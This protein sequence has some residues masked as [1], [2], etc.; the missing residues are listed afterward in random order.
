MGNVSRVADKIVGQDV[1]TVQEVEPALMDATGAGRYLAIS[2]HTIRSWTRQGRLQAVRFGRMLR[3][4][5]ADLDMLVV[6]RLR[7][8]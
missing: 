7:R 1:G 3:Y 4:R 6:A 8:A 5:R 2:P